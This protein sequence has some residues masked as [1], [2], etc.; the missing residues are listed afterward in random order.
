MQTL[1]RGRRELFKKFEHL[2]YAMGETSVYDTRI[3]SRSIRNCHSVGNTIIIDGLDHRLGIGKG[4]VIGID[5][6]LACRIQTRCSQSGYVGILK[7]EF[8]SDTLEDPK[9]A[10]VFK[11]ACGSVNTSFVGEIKLLVYHQDLLLPEPGR[12]ACLLR[13]RVAPSGR[14]CHVTVLWLS[15]VPRQDLPSAD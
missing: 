9:A 7:P 2:T 6:R 8:L 12:S 15:V 11:E 5:K 3:V 4:R 10:D 14:T 13:L 1:Y